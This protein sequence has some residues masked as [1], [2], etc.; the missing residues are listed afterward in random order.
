MS[1]SDKAQKELGKEIQVELPSIVIWKHI[2]GYSNY[3]VNNLGEIVNLD[4]FQKLKPLNR[5]KLR[6]KYVDLYNKYG[7]KK[8]SI[9]R[10]VCS[11]KNNHNQ[12]PQVNHINSDPSCNWLTNLEW[13]TQ[14]ENQKH[15]YRFGNQKPSYVTRGKFGK[16]SH[17]HKKIACHF[18]DGSHRIFDTAK[19]AA[20][21]LKISYQNVAQSARLEKRMSRKKV[22][23]K[24]I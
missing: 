10:L 20:S 21:E 11:I 1:I 4:T 9:H 5:N 13:C 3:C 17:N 22:T 8:K 16:E 23:F 15:A 6:Y 2:M 24:Y 19:I 12:K 14:S 18:D 7:V